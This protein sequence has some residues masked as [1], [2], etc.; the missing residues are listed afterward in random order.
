MTAYL[1]LDM[2][3]NVMV[4]LAAVV[5]F[6]AVC[7]ATHMQQIEKKIEEK[8][9]KKELLAASYHCTPSAADL[10]RVAEEFPGSFSPEEILE[11]EGACISALDAM[12]VNVIASL[13]ELYELLGD[14]KL[15]EEQL[16]IIDHNA[17]KC[18]LLLEF[19]LYMQNHGVPAFLNYM[20]SKDE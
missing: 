4:I 19:Q 2:I 16:S 12:H 6:I 14:D 8:E 9:R 17:Y 10:E 20:Q 13:D 5:L 1:V 18:R 11:A 3:T 7:L 15:T